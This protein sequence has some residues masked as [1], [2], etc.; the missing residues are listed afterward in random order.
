MSGIGPRNAGHGITGALFRFLDS[1]IAPPPSA[2]PVIFRR[3]LQVFLRDTT[4]V[5]FPLVVAADQVGVVLVTAAMS[6]Y[7]IQPTDRVLLIDTT[8]GGVVA[9]A[10][11]AGGP[12]L[13]RPIQY[14]DAKRNFGVDSFTLNGNGKN[15]SGS[16]SLIFAAAGSNGVIEWGG[17]EWALMGSN[18]S[19]SIFDPAS[20]GPIGQTTPSSVRSTVVT[21]TGNVSLSGTATPTAATATSKLFAALNAISNLVDGFGFRGEDGQVGFLE[22]IGPIASAISRIRLLRLSLLDNGTYDYNTESH[23]GLAIVC[24]PGATGST[25]GI[26]SYAANG[27]TSL[28]GLTFTTVTATLTS[29]TKFN[30]GASGGLLRFENKTG[31]PVTPIVLLLQLDA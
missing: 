31:S 12:S 29:A 25:W 14:I 5:E 18:G 11:A 15:I 6:P 1:I 30:V 7:D 8:G 9:N 10:P 28:A 27:A 21:A 2:D 20:P 24:L 19:G 26:V 23:G 17:T 3:G 16:S 13:G 4:G 22:L